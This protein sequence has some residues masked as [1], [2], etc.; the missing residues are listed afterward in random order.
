MTDELIRYM[1][2]RQQWHDLR[3]IEGRDKG[4]TA[5]DAAGG[6]DATLDRALVE[7]DAAWRSMTPDDQSH[8]RVLTDIR[9][10]PD[11]DKYEEILKN[12]ENYQCRGRHAS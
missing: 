1:W 5:A 9:W 2:L 11:N 7:I 12:P 6:W 8:A 3:E 4:R 10:P